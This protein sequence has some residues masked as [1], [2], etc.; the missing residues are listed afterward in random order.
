[1]GEGSSCAIDFP[2][3]TEISMAAAGFVVQ[4]AWCEYPGSTRVWRL[5][6]YFALTFSL[7]SNRDA[8]AHK[9]LR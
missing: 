8:H 5:R 9:V 2:R 3:R 6:Q 4:A 1:M 7:T